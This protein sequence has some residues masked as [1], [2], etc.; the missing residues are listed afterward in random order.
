MSDIL[1]ALGNVFTIGNLAGLIFG[2][3]AGILIG[4][5]PGLSV[6][7]G[8]ALLFPLTFAFQGVGGILM[9]LGIYC[10]AIY[11]GSISAILLKTPGT[12]ASVATTLDG[13]PMA[14]KLKQP[15]R[16]LGLSTFGSTFGGIFSAICLIIFSPM[17]ASVALKFSKPEYFALA[18]FGL[19]IITSVSSGSILKGLLGGFIGLFIA[20]IGFLLNRSSDLLDCA[21]CF[22]FYISSGRY[23]FRTDSD[24]T[25][26]FFSGSSERG[27]LL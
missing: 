13:Y 24:R 3:G 20:T 5:M 6:N 26:C 14:T 8:I 7:M 16:A 2:T 17:L 12:P 10:G 22:W 4:A 9:L 21:F 25:V 27:G 23:F 15:G 18:V 11:G 1:V 19:S